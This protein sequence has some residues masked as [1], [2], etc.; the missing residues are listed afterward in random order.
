MNVVLK[1][2]GNPLLKSVFVR[3]QLAKLSTLRIWSD[4]VCFGLIL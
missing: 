2:S 1:Q 4:R 3:K